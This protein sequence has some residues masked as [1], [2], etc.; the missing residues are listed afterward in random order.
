MSGADTRRNRQP[1]RTQSGACDAMGIDHNDPL[2]W[3]DR[4]RQVARRGVI[5]ADDHMVLAS[6]VARN[7]HAVSRAAESAGI[8]ERQRQ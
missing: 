2:A 6:P 1:I 5:E 7:A 8:E 3:Q 4:P